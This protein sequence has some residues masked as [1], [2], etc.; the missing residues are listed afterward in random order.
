L[1]G[2][3]QLSDY[4]NEELHASLFMGEGV[5]D[6]LRGAIWC[7]MLNIE[8]LKDCQNGLYSKLVELTNHE[9]EA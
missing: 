2:S 4:S 7:K 8:K 9:L 1:D 3:A 6:N 5:P